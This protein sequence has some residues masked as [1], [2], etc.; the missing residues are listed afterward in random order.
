MADY[1]ELV[2]EHASYSDRLKF[3]GA[4]V[5]DKTELAR[6]LLKNR[7]WNATTNVW[8]DENAIKALHIN[9]VPVTYLIDSE[10]KVIAN[11]EDTDFQSILAKLIYGISANRA[12]N[13]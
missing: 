12:P 10:G 1:Q 2:K 7:E 6:E 8:L 13:Q 3:V 5:D 9:S 11:S 4:S